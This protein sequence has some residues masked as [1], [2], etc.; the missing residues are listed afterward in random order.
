[1]DAFVTSTAS[2]PE[3]K[4]HMLLLLSIQ[5]SQMTRLISRSEPKMGPNDSET[6]TPASPRLPTNR[7]GH[8]S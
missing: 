4:P 2:K 1:M 3:G 8:S 5:L 7:F 6:V